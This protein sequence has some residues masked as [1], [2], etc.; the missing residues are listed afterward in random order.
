MDRDHEANL[1]P[2]FGHNPAK[3]FLVN[4]ILQELGLTNGHCQL[5]DIY[6]TFRHRSSSM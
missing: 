2:I 1:K 6:L 4:P 5:K 3:R